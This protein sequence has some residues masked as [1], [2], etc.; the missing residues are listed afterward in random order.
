MNYQEQET[1]CQQGWLACVLVRN[2]EP[3]PDPLPEP[4]LGVIVQG[5]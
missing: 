3:V 1:D 5:K 2:Q 4:V